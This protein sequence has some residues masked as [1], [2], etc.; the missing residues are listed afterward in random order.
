MQK[1]RREG[2]LNPRG[3]KRPQAEWY[4]RK[5]KASPG[6]LPTWLGDPGTERLIMLS[7]FIIV[8]SHNL[9]LYRRSFREKG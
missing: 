8:F 5:G 1:K 2:D 3:P 9:N 7:G 6:L 4:L